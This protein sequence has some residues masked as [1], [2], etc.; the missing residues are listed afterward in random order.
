[1]HRIASKLGATLKGSK[2]FPLSAA[3]MVKKQTIYV[4]VTLSVIFF[5]HALC[6]CVIYVLSATPINSTTGTTNIK[7]RRTATEEPPW[8]GRQKTTARQK[9][10]PRSS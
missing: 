8:K 1:M 9:S 7:Q 5:I 2:F 4:N 6:I 3:P 10:K